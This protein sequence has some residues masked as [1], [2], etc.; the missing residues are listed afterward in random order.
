[1]HRLLDERLR[2]VSSD[3][4]DQSSDNR[5]LVE[6][7]AGAQF[8]DS[9]EQLV[10]ERLEDGRVRIQSLDRDARLARAQ[11]AAERATLRDVAEIRVRLDDDRSVPAQLER[12]SCRGRNLLEPPPDRG[13]A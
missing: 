13:T 4:V 7:I 6:R 11:E 5:R 12:H 9:L 2:L 1:R 8:G 10:P 3:L